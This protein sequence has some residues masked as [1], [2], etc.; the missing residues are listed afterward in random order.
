MEKA[1][2]KRRGL[3][4]KIIL[5]SGSLIFF[6]RYLTP[7]SATTQKRLEVEESEIPPGAALIYKES[8][9]AVIRSN[10]EI[11]ALD[12]TC[13]HLGCTVR[14]TPTELVCPCHGS[15]FD[16]TGQVLHGPADRP[17][18]RLTVKKQ[19]SKLLVLT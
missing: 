18:R 10:T 15:R 16:R 5:A 6:W 12:L 14:V 2:Q 1:D 9:V 19:G 8:R 13:T 4:K 7:E 3:L 17:L 11:Y